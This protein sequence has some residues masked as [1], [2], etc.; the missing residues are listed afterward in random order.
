MVDGLISDLMVV[1]MIEIGE[2]AAFWNHFY[3]VL[4]FT[5]IVSN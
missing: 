5:L 1:V 3:L 4:I 2:N